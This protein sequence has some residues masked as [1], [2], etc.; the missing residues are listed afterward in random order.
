V[1]G[2]A[3][4]KP[5]CECLGTTWTGNPARDRLK[6][7]GPPGRGRRVR[8]GVSRGS[9]LAQQAGVRDQSLILASCG[10]CR[11]CISGRPRTWRRMRGGGS[12]LCSDSTVSERERRIANSFAGHML[13]KRTP[14]SPPSALITHAV[15]DFRER[16]S[17]AAPTRVANR[18]RWCGCA[19]VQGAVR[20]GMQT[21]AITTGADRQYDDRRR[22]QARE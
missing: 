9:Q 10:T 6:T 14:L 13:P 1:A 5:Y 19:K 3:I 18:K 15:R 2:P 7:E 17:A 4:L 20:S 8:H 12:S 22:P 16:D 11:I 21:H